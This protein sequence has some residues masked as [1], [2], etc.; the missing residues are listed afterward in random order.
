MISIIKK[1]LKQEIFK[2]NHNFQVVLTYA[3]VKSKNPHVAKQKDVWVKNSSK[4]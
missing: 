3:S 1:V 2:K 4:E